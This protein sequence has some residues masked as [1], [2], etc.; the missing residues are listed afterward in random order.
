MSRQANPAGSNGGWQW[1]NLSRECLDYSTTAGWLDL[2]SEVAD[3]SSPELA[4][5][6]SWLLTIP[7]GMRHL[8]GPRLAMLMTELNDR[9]AAILEGLEP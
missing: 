1:E 4:Y 3:M 8:A 5:Q 9:A 6:V 7:H 2:R